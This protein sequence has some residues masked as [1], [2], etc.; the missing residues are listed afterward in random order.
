[1]RTNVNRRR[2]VFFCSTEYYFFFISQF[3][4]NMYS[5][6]RH[7]KVLD[8]S[9]NAWLIV[10]LK[11]ILHKQESLI[12]NY[13]TFSLHLF[14]TFFASAFPSC[15]LRMYI[16]LTLVSPSMSDASV[17]CKTEW[18]SK[19]CGTSLYNMLSFG[20]WVWLTNFREWEIKREL[21]KGFREGGKIM[22]ECE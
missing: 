8:K 9:E 21:K 16:S 14:W 20:T 17:R 5:E 11:T 19:K 13:I 2:L 3:G 10:A 7:S 1:M 12:A 4:R 6:M 22:G 18:L 15:L